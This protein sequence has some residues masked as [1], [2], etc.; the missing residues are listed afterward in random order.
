MPAVNTKA[1][2]E[3]LKKI[4]TPVAEG[5]HAV[6]ILARRTSRPPRGN[7]CTGCLKRQPG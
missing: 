4:A 6:L 3:H 2:D 1:M 5:A 7:C